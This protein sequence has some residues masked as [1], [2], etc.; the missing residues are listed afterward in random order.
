MLFGLLAVPA[1]TDGLTYVTSVAYVTSVR[2]ESHESHGS[3]QSHESQKV[4]EVR[5]NPN[6][7]QTRNLMYFI[8]DF[9]AERMLGT[10]IFSAPYREEFSPPANELCSEP[11]GV[12]GRAQ[13]FPARESR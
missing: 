12:G 6:V 1:G 10:L 3:H 5:G 13:R 2:H 9:T 4:T 11:I 8:K 7:S